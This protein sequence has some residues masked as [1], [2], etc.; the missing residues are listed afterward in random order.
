M[1]KK[2]GWTLSFGGHSGN[3]P[4]VGDILGED[5][6]DTEAVDLINKCF[7]F[8]RENAKKKERTSRFIERIGLEEFKKKVL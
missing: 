4:R 2:N 7:D 8:Y 3:R 5:L 6:S 1:G